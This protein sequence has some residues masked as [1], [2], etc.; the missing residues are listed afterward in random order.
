MKV[1][2][3]C[4]TDDCATAASLYRDLREAGADACQFGESE[5]VGSPGVFG[6]D[7]RWSGTVHVHPRHRT[8]SAFAPPSPPALEVADSPIGT[9]VTWLEVPDATTYVLE[10]TLRPLVNLT[11]DDWRSVYEGDRTMYLDFNRENRTGVAY[12]Y[13]AKARGPW[14]E[15]DWSTDVTG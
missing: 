5:T 11:T 4:S 1:F 6:P 13:R 15:T 3:S 8:R 10:R 7:S 12:A 14:G 2:I 9:M